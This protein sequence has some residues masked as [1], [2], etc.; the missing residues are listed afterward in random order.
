M[1]T[2]VIDDELF[3][4]ILTN[5]KLLLNIKEPDS[6]STEQQ[7]EL[8]EH[9]IKIITLY[10]NIICQNICIKTN[11]INF[12]KDLKYLVIE[13]CLDAYNLYI[14]DSTPDSNN[15]I[16][17]MSEEGRTVSFGISD[18]IKTKF[19]LLAQQKI[20]DNNNLINKYKLLYK[21]ECKHE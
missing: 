21:V 10:I 2:N 15:S 11:R 5:V 16:Q 1:G 6:D 17:S 9:T 7:K 12:P 13:S 3:N 14:Q 8:Y 20:N 4:F 18:T 19:Q